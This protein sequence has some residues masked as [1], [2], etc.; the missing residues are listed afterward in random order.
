MT[1]LTFSEV[2]NTC[3]AD[4]TVDFSP[5]DHGDDYPFDGPGGVLG[6]AFF[7]D[8]GRLHFDEAEEFTENSTRGINLGIVATHE[9]GH[10]LG[11]DH[12]FVKD[13]VMYPYYGGFT[14]NFTLTTDDILGIQ[15]LYGLFVL[16][17]VFY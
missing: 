5:T 1:D 13:A 4:I 3:K 2:C 11:L 7:P 16:C 9:I 10:I 8:D 6:H 17:V 12:S 15:S 14:L